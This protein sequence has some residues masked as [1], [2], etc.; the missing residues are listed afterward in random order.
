MT[1]QC[2]S[3]EELANYLGGRLDDEQSSVLEA[4][5]ATCHNCEDTL[6]ELDA[7]DDTLIRTL[8]MRRAPN[9][10]PDNSPSWVESMASRPDGAVDGEISG[11]VEIGDTSADATAGEIGDY[12]ILSLLGRGGMSIV[13]AARHVHLGRDVALK[14]LLPGTEGQAITRE[15]FAREMRTVGTL[16]HPAIV[17]ATDAGHCGDRMYLVMD[18][19]DGIDLS[20]VSRLE[21]PLRVAD[22]CAIGVD[23]ALGLAYAHDQGVVHRDIKPSN[24]MLDRQGSVKILDF[25]LARLQ[26][27]VCDISLQTTMGQLLGTLDYMA[28]E[29]AGG[30]EVDLRADIY[31]LGATIFKLLTGLPPH[32]RSAEMPIVAYLHRLATCDVPSLEPVDEQ[33]PGE[34]TDLLRDMLQRDPARRPQNGINIAERL[35]PFA[36]DADLRALASSAL[37]K[38]VANGDADSHDS[39]VAIRKSL[40][41]IRGTAQSDGIAHSEPIGDGDQQV[42]AN[43]PESG[44]RWDWRVVTAVGL[45]GL[46]LCAVIVTIKSPEGEIQIESEIDSVKVDLVDSQNRV[47]TIAVEQGTSSTTVRA[48]R[49][50]VQLDAPSDAVAISP[51]EITVTKNAVAIARIRKLTNHGQQANARADNPESAAMLQSRQQLLETEGKLAEAKLDPQR[52]R[53]LIASLESQIKTLKSLSRPVPTEPVYEGRT[54]SDWLALMRYEQNRDERDKAMEGVRILARFQRPDVET[55]ALLERE[56]AYWQRHSYG[57]ERS[58]VSIME[59]PEND[60]GD[61]TTRRLAELDRNVVEPRL[62]AL[63]T[64]DNVDRRRLALATCV[65]LRKDLRK[66]EWPQLMAALRQPVAQD[67]VR[68]RALYVLARAVVE[69]DDAAAAK[70]LTTLELD[71]ESWRTGYAALYATDERSLPV[72][73]EK[74]LEWVARVIER[75][76]MTWDFQNPLLKYHPQGSD[77][78]SVFTA[79]KVGPFQ[80]VNWD[81]LDAQSQANVNHM[82]DFLLASYERDLNGKDDERF[83]VVSRQ[84][85]A[86][87]EIIAECDLTGDTNQRAVSL[88]ARRWEQL[89]KY[90][91]QCDVRDMPPDQGADSPMAVAGAILLLSGDVPE[92]FKVGTDGVL[93]SPSLDFWGLSKVIEWYPYDVLL[94]GRRRI[95]AARLSDVRAP[96]FQLLA[97]EFAVTHHYPHLLWLFSKPQ[98]EWRASPDKEVLD[99][100][101]RHATFRATLL[102]WLAD[103]S[104]EKSMVRLCRAL[105]THQVCLDLANQW[106]DEGDLAHQRVALWL[107]GTNEAEVQDLDSRVS[108][109]I[110]RIINEDSVRTLDLVSLLR[111]Q[112]SRPDIIPF[113]EYFL[114]AWLRDTEF[115]IDELPELKIDHDWSLLTHCIDI[116]SQ[117]PELLEQKW[118]LIEKQLERYDPRERGGILKDIWKRHPELRREPVE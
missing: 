22:A 117:R 57:P 27:A 45:L 109:V 66:G 52:N 108:R 16:A 53:S 50:R 51:Q 31:S 21:G 10:S 100:V 20:G 37:E 5:L 86:L 89:M 68:D 64:G 111:L 25:G 97:T 83:E 2:Y 110:A 49:Y 71:D 74:Q 77:A 118:P 62:C 17:R 56:L 26:S 107:L 94:D 102:K 114:D 79:A 67:I 54:F 87:V 29:Q 39:C 32:G 116:I 23:L 44:S 36:A 1:T 92:T 115:T 38:K 4:H 78:A 73:I 85:K 65:S 63:L 112:Y 11:S 40:K 69:S 72:A 43:P 48:G 30:A 101:H 3:R 99:L 81:E 82:V 113:G 59:Y 104:D 18:R 13:F 15:R 14:V 58:C 95:D 93:V 75:T 35:R 106:L 76:A 6:A 90:R 105:L 19:I 84:T 91:A 33:V 88:L 60:Y 12:R 96:T 42:Q 24:V 9:G 103:S 80:A 55:D 8:Q 41:E 46:L 7:S 70:H 34:L 28:P 98:D 47:D 61:S